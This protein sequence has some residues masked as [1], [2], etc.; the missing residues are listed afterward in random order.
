MTLTEN[1]FDN[2]YTY[3]EAIISTEF[4]PESQSGMLE[5]YGEDYAQV[6]AINNIAPKTVWAMVDS[7]DGERMEIIA[8]IQSR[9]S[10]TPIYYVITNEEWSNEEEKYV[11]G[12]FE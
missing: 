1:E 3:N 4:D 7:E 6:V 5:T 12:E 10:A 11:I 2:K 9:Y 8:G